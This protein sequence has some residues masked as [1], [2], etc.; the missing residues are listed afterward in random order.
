MTD[1]LVKRARDGKHQQAVSEHLHAMLVEF[2][3]AVSAMASSNRALKVDYAFWRAIEA[4]GQVPDH[5]RTDVTLQAFS[6]AICATDH[7][8]GAAKTDEVEWELERLVYASGKVL[9]E[10]ISGNLSQLSHAESKHWAC[11]VR[12]CDARHRRRAS[13]LS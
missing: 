10:R 3:R 13:R 1:D 5:L 11:A 12:L 4:L 7:D 6:Q 8:R 9:A 2:L